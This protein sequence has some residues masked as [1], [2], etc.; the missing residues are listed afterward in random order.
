M[1]SSILD[2]KPQALLPTTDRL[3]VTAR[4]HRTYRYQVAWRNCFH[5]LVSR[6]VP[7]DGQTASTMFTVAIL[8]LP[9]NRAIH[10]AY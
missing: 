2:T 1:R 9:N 3:T 4:W 7:F 5:R 8:R 6:L 10:D